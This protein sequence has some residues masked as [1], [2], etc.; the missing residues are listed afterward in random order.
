MQIDLC[1]RKKIRYRYGGVSD[2]SVPEAAILYLVE[3]QT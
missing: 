3:L 1:V 2:L